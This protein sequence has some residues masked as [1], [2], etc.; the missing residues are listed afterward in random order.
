[1]I[2]ISDHLRNSEE[3]TLSNME[4]SPPQR[5][6][7]C[8]KQG[9]G[10]LT[11]LAVCTR[12]KVTWK[13]QLV[14]VKSK[15]R[16]QKPAWPPDPPSLWPSLCL[17]LPAWMMCSAAAQYLLSRCLDWGWVGLR[18][19]FCAR[20]YINKQFVFVLS[21]IKCACSYFPFQTGASVPW[22]C[23]SWVSVSFPS[24]SIIGR[25]FGIRGH[26]V[27]YSMP[28]KAARICWRTHKTAPPVK[29]MLML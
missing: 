1:M 12:S 29:G 22:L 24:E 17:P 25:I 20:C 3:V 7:P 6:S 16:P 26:Q 11:G 18:A 4:Q 2:N 14:S 19:P 8:G 23:I 21:L 15:R 9:E 10:A 28:N 13:E 27:N 5:N